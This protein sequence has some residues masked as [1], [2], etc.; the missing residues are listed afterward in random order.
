M[1]ML[2]VNYGDKPVTFELIRK[3]VK[4]I[5]LTVQPDQSIFVSAN[6]EVDILEIKAFVQS[7]GRWILSKLN[8]FKRHAPYVKIPREYVTGETF[9]YLGRQYKL[10]VIE[11]EDEFVRY[12]R[13][14]IE[15]YVKDVEDFRTKERLMEDWYE[16]RREAVFQDSLNRMYELARVYDIDFPV[17]ETRKMRLRWGSYLPRGNKVIL[18]KD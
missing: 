9:R 4:H 5:N 11:A 6:D 18:N 3:D 10:S 14:T 2:T 15:M 17:L 8:Y 13:G 1:M 7:K 16:N 12:F